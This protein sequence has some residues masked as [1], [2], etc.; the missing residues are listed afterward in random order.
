MQMS[1]YLFP[2]Q[3]FFKAGILSVRLAMKSK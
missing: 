3:A 2:L 1:V